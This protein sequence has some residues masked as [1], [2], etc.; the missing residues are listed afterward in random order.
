MKT[1]ALYMLT[2]LS[3]SGESYVLDSHLTLED[4]GTAIAEGFAAVYVEG[5]SGTASASP[6]GQI[7][8]V[9]ERAAYSCEVM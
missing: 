9:P 7:V 5:A 8:P 4:C 6:A 1:L 2:L 3:P